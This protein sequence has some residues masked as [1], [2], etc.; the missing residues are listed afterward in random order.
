MSSKMKQ[1]LENIRELNAEERALLAHCLISSLHETEDEGSDDAWA[2]LAETR[3]DQLE[4]GETK[5]VGWQ[6]IKQ[7]LKS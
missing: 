4:S 2:Q 3:F 7:R 5:A 6:Q 1:V